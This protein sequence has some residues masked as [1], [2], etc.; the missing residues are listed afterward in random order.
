MTSFLLLS[1]LLK[2]NIASKIGRQH[3]RGKWRKIL[4]FAMRADLRWLIS[5]K[6][7]G[8]VMHTSQKCCT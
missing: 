2:A 8:T 6:Q 3:R 4:P 7:R 1:F 5:A